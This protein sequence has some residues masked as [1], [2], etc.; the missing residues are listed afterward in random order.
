MREQ[1]SEKGHFHRVNRSSQATLQD[2]S[3]D[4]QEVRTPVVFSCYL[5]K[6]SIGFLLKRGAIVPLSSLMMRILIR[7]LKVD[8][9]SK[10]TSIILPYLVVSGA[11]LSKF[12]GSGQ[13][14]ICA[15]RIYV[16]SNVYAEFASRL[17]ERVAAFKV[18]NGIEEGM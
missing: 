17:A 8:F 11:I 10:S 16:Q 2:G 1:F 5:W 15:N 3:F 13:T 7:L 12:R 18:G 9:D 4:H 14:C 6:T